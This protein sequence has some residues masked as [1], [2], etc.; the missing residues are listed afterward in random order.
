M[1]AAY[2]EEQAR[3]MLE[4]KPADRLLRLAKDRSHFFFSLTYFQPKPLIAPYCF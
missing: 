1:E 4:T 3:F 2:T